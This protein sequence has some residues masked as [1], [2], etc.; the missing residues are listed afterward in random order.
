LQTRQFQP[1]LG[2]FQVGLGPAA[3]IFIL[4]Q[5]QFR[6]ELIFGNFI[7]ASNMYLCNSPFGAK[8]KFLLLDGRYAPGESQLVM[9]GSGIAVGVG[10]DVFAEV[11]EQAAKN[12]MDAPVMKNKGMR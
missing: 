7:A 10:W 9:T 2:N 5:L 1:E 6:K 12:R 11:I 4:A 3:R 8:R